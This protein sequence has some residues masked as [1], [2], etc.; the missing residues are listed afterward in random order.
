MPDDLNESFARSVRLL[1]RAL[2]VRREPAG[3]P[4]GRLRFSYAELAAMGLVH[5]APGMKARDVAEALDLTPTTT[6]SMLD[7]LVRQGLVERRKHADEKRAVALSLTEAG[8]AA[9]EGIRAQDARNAALML[10]AL[11]Q[12]SRERFVRDLERI[13]AALGEGRDG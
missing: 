5:D 9:I 10:E 12:R 13:A 3:D 4:H 8:R 1:L 2:A 11:P 7:R 6:Q